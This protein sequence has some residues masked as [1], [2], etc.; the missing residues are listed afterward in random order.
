MRNSALW[1][2]CFLLAAASAASARDLVSIPVVDHFPLHVD[3]ETLQRKG[4]VLTFK[5]VLAVPKGLGKDS[6]EGW[7]S[8]EVDTIIDCKD[9]TYSLGAITIYAEPLGQGEVKRS[10]PAPPGERRSYDIRPR[11][12]AGYLA[13]F[14]CK[15]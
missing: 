2:C 4:A 14:L 13:D 9:E 10:V 8:T 1:S 5:Y 7:E 12:T 6:P 3:K 11:S 15:S